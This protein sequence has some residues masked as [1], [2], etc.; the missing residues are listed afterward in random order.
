[1]EEE[2]KNNENN[3]KQRVTLL[4]GLVTLLIAVLGATYAYFQISAN[5]EN[6]NTNITGKTPDKSLVT[7]KQVTSN[8]HLNISASDMSYENRT[9]E[10]YATAGEDPYVGTEEL[11]TKTI[12][13]IEL[14]GGEETT[15][16]SCTAKLTVSKVMDESNPDT[17]IEVL[18]PGDIILQFKGNL[19]NEQLDLNELKENNPKEYNLSFKVKGNSPEEIQAYIKF[20]NKDENQNYLA[21]RKLNIDINIDNLKCEVYVEHPTVAKLRVDDEQGYLSEDIQGDMYRYQGTGDITNWICFG[22]DNKEECTN[23]KDH[24]MYRIIGITPEGEMKLI[25]QTP[26]VEEGNKIFSWFKATGTDENG[27]TLYGTAEKGFETWPDSLIYKRLNGLSNGKITGD[28]ANH[29]KS[30]NPNINVDTDIFVDSSEYEYLKSG[31]ENGTN[32]GIGSEWYK[33]IS[34][35]EWMYGDTEDSFNFNGHEMYKAETGQIE[36]RYNYFDSET[37]TY[38][39]GTYTWNKE[40]DKVTAKIGLPY[41]YDF[42]LAYYDGETEDTRGNPGVSSLGENWL[43][44]IGP[45]E[46]HVKAVMERCTKISGAPLPNTWAAFR[47]VWSASGE[48][49]LCNIIDSVTYTGTGLQHFPTF[50]L[51]NTIEMEGT[52]IE[53]DPY[54]I[55]N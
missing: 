13:S 18:Q 50:Y 52:G 35:H 14:T 28:G 6:N 2:I 34:D 46:D 37:S 39:S 43:L 40:T 19:I 29:K 53:T 48:D 55:V 8:L 26:V 12:A 25:K 21:G 47:S 32:D 10:Y 30:S 38:K 51:P 24:Y 36:T 20:L 7:L 45:N 22:T 31:D 49:G 3:K 27:N 54:R 33:I 42:Y 4:I 23:D 17:M 16:Y 1:M 15:R 44:K 9:H 5:T 41:L 11:G